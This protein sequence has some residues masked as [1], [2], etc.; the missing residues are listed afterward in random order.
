MQDSLVLDRSSVEHLSE[1]ADAVKQM[2]AFF[3]LC[4]S[5]NLNSAPIAQAPGGTEN[6]WYSVVVCG[7]A[8]YDLSGTDWRSLALDGLFGV[9]DIEDASANCVAQLAAIGE[10]DD[11]IRAAGGVATDYQKQAVLSKLAALNQWLS[12]KAQ[13]LQNGF[14]ELQHLGTQAVQSLRDGLAQE[15]AREAAPPLEGGSQGPYFDQ[16]QSVGKQL[17]ALADALNAP[18]D[19]LMTAWTA[20]QT[21]VNSVAA[22]MAAA[23]AADLGGLLQQ[24]DVQSSL[25]QW[26]ELCALAV[27]FRPGPRPPLPPAPPGF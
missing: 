15:L 4:A 23:S 3:G 13:A 1:V 19:T 6:I 14:N 20:M 22:R 24:L 26:P 16:Y 5:L 11:E 21:M 27:S 7:T 9:F 17:I 12:G 25:G 2:D 18:S 10:L 8:W